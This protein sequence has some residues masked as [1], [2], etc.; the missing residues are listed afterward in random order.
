MGCTGRRAPW[1][2]ALRVLAGALAVVAVVVLPSPPAH[3]ARHPSAATGS[4]WSWPVQPLPEVLR[5]FEPPRQRWSPGHRGIDLAAVPGQ[6]M[7]APAAGTVSFAGVVVDRGVL[8]ITH[9]GGL[10]SSVEPV[11]AL[12]ARGAEVA[13]GQ[14]VAVL[15]PLV[16]HCAPR[17]CLHWGVR[18][19]DVYLDP[20]R[21]VLPPE[22]SVLLPLV[23]PPVVRRAGPGTRAGPPVGV[24]GVNRAQGV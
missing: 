12:V 6:Q 3:A 16:A 8:T 18:R 22:P 1:S 13:R 17:P 2:L 5:G 14:P 19:G 11:T 21:L 4:G 10:R 15:D 9:A 20:L 7:L 24:R 23:G